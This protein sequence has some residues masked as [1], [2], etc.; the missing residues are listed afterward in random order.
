MCSPFWHAMRERPV[1]MEGAM[2]KGFEYLMLAA[3]ISIVGVS[4]AALGAGL[5]K[6]KSTPIPTKDGLKWRDVVSDDFPKGMK[7]AVLASSGDYS[8][9]R[10]IV[11]PHAVIRP[12]SHPAAE[13]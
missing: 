10:V 6:M 4:T 7:A 2:R 12:H 1:Q 11:P 3:A 8:V 5:E 13:A 9:T